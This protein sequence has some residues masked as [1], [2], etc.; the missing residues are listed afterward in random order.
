MSDKSS[1]TERDSTLPERLCGTDHS[2]TTIVKGNESVSAHGK[3]AKESEAR[4]KEKADK[5]GW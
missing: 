2:K 4:A 1:R 5:K 3:D